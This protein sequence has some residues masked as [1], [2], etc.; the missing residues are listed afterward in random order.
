[1]W[2][3]GFFG[4]HVAVRRQLVGLGS[5][6]PPL[7]PETELKPLAWPGGTCAC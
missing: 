4:V 6:S 5:F 2:G 7:G 1:M 3:L